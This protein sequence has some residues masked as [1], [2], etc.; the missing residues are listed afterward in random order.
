MYVWEWASN[1]TVSP[2]SSAFWLSL[3]MMSLAPGLAGGPLDSGNQLSLLPFRIYRPAVLIFYTEGHRGDRGM[4][5]R[6]ERQRERERERPRAFTDKSLGPGYSLFK[7]NSSG[8]QHSQQHQ[9]SKWVGV[10]LRVCGLPLWAAYA[11]TTDRNTIH[12]VELHTLAGTQGERHNI[13]YQSTALVHTCE[14]SHPIG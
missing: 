10:C 4:E 12:F 13:Q 14:M 3:R 1:G 2:Y 8:Y 5:W 6:R 7:E 11:N 9:I